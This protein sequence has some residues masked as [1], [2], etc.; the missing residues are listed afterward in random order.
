VGRASN[1]S[2]LDPELFPG[3][4]RDWHWTATANVDQSPVNQYNYGNVMKSRKPPSSAESTLLSGWA[5][6]LESGES[7]GDMSRNTK[8][9][10]RLVMTIE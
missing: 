1:P 8:M 3:A 5:V 10:V 9:S 2:G 4:P 6:N 7:R